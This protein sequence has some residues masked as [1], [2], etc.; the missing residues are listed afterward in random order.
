M[1]EHYDRKMGTQVT[2]ILGNHRVN[3]KKEK[4]RQNSLYFTALFSENFS[5]HYLT[6]YPIN[7][8]ISI[9]TLQ[10]YIN[11]V[12]NTDPKDDTNICIKVQPC[13]EKFVND[14]SG[15]LDLLN[16][17][18]VFMSDKLTKHL[19]HIITL[20]WLRPE[21]LLDIWI[22][23]QNLGLD[24][25][26]DVVYEA[27]LDR[28]NDLPL[29]GIMGLSLE[30]LVKLIGNVNVNSAET[31]LKFIAQESIEKI[32]DSS[33]YDP[34]NHLFRILMKIADNPVVVCHSMSKNTK[35]KHV[36]C[37]AAL[38]YDN[39]R[40][41]IPCVY[42]FR[43]K[44]F[45]ELVDLTSIVDILDNGKEVFGRQI[46]G[47]GFSIYVIGGEQGIGSGRFIKTIWR[48]CLLSSTWF[49]V[50]EL[51]RPRRHMA[52]AFIKNNLFLIGGVGSHRV[53]LSSVDVLN[54]HTKL[55]TRIRDIPEMFTEVP[56]SCVINDKLVYH[57][58]N[59]YVY[60]LK[61]HRWDTIEMSN[62]QSSATVRYHV[63]SLIARNDSECC[64]DDNI[65]IG[66]VESDTMSKTSLSRFH[67]GRNL[68]KQIQPIHSWS[69]KYYRQIFD[70]STLIS[71]SY[72]YGR[73]TVERGIVKNIN[74][75]THIGTH[76][77]SVENMHDSGFENRLGCFNI[78][79][80]AL[81]HKQIS[82]EDEE[83]IDV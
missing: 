24:V 79:D 77:Q 46:I 78:I 37:V 10:D 17:S 49:P 71:F 33:D 81:L 74:T 36:Q 4:L 7:Y 1:M 21:K 11:W 26:R 67:L 62:H 54:I 12:E 59:F 73:V 68:N 23:A 66:V 38:K 3:A 20:Y 69:N 70:G 28:F 14:D 55:W 40:G 44:V 30:N 32:R 76:A 15:L 8:D 18:I 5:D 35:P 9:I 34:S 27:C 19:T 25:L 2:L 13:L 48:Y 50:A 58:T 52:V 75:Y 61:A 63:D 56:A 42:W 57:K 80:P 47:R 6:E 16:L 31:R 51:P 64:S 43:E 82:F 65:Y 72:K 29:E 45:T 39:I 41:K 53:K 22:L 83:A 60:D